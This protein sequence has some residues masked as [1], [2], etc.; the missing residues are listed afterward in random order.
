VYY[1][2]VEVSKPYRIAP[3]TPTPF[4]FFSPHYYI[5][6]LKQDKVWAYGKRTIDG[7]VLQVCLFIDTE[8][9]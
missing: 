8:K 1:Y 6:E 9:L 3:P 7:E 4:F 5:I 2:T